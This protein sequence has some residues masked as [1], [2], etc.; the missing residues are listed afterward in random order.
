[1]RAVL[2]RVSR[3]TVRVNGQTSGEIGPGLLI[4]LA[5]GQ[6]DT[7]KEADYLLDK[8]VNLRIFEDAEGKMNLS[9]LDVGGELLVISQF[10]LYADC[11]KGRRPSFTDAG[12]PGEAQKLYD[13]FVA[14]ARTRG[15]KVATGIFQ[16]VM[17]VELV[18]SG[19]VTILLDSSKNF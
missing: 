10:T 14:A 4:L 2:Q 16:A 12:P 6:G 19:P 1:M 11:R 17:E 3:A 15:V 7:S 18:N 9:L 13:Y 5:V 8:I